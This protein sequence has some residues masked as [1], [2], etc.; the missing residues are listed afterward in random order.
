MYIQTYLQFTAG[1]NNLEYG[2]SY[3]AIIYNND[4]LICTKVYNNIAIIY[5]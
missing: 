5:Q 1:Y 3:T 2:F 4:S